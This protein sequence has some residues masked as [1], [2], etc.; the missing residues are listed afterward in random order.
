MS[1]SVEAAQAE[2]RRQSDRVKKCPVFAEGA[3]GVEAAYAQAYQTLVRLGVE[4][5]IRKKYRK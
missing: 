4:P 3:S 5:Q 1:E 2:F